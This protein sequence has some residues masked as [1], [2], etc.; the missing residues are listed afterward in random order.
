M[1]QNTENDQKIKKDILRKNT[2]SRRQALERMGVT[3]GTGVM[4]T[5]TLMAACKNASAPATSSTPATSATPTPP[6][7]TPATSTPASTTTPGTTTTTST[8]PAS[9]PAANTTT[10][11]T[12]VTTTTA[13]GTTTTQPA[14]STPPASTPPPSTPAASTT[15][16]D[17][18]PPTDLPPLIDVP[19]SSCQVATDRLYSFEHVWVK[20]IGDDTVVLGITTSLVEI[21]GEPYKM[22]FPDVGQVLDQ[23]GGFGEIEGYKVSAD[24][25]TPVSGEV[26]QINTFLKAWSGSAVMQP[27]ETDPYNSGWM[28]AVKLS[29]PEELDGLLTPQG[30][31]QRLGKG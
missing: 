29:K 24:L 8:P 9:T 14:A 17:Y 23:D 18:I 31:I 27:V 26:L 19:D 25:I 10:G 20:N 15:G 30:Y 28:I 21:L 6:S 16:F 13:P 4:A 12:P 5:L 2:F 11:N 1:E 7:T 22:T 3:V